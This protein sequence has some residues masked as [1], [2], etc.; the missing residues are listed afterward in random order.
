MNEVKNERNELSRSVWLC[1]ICE[2]PVESVHRGGEG[3]TMYVDFI[4]SEGVNC[5]IRPLLDRDG[6]MQDQIHL[7][8]AKNAPEGAYFPCW[9]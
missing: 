8:C 1:P 4:N 7:N 2:K 5:G 3:I 9:L 6:N